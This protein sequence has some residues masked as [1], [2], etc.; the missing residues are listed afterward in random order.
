MCCFISFHFIEPGPKTKA[1]RI[2]IL[3]GGGRCWSKE[4]QKNP[5]KFKLCIIMHKICILYNFLKMPKNVGRALG[6]RWEGVGRALAGGEG[7]IYRQI[8]LL[9]Y[10]GY[11][12]VYLV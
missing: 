6:G 12:L 5:R 1:L 8:K 7:W 4:Y 9:H 2:L 10:S 3:F 11:L